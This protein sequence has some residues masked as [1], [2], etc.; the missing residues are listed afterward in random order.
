VG[1]AIINKKPGS[2]EKNFSTP[3]LFLI[4]IL[5]PVEKKTEKQV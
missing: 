5:D 3:P 4:E 2:I 1:T